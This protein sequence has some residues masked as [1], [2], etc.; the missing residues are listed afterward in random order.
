MRIVLFGPSGSGKGTL[1]GSLNKRYNLP[2]VSSGDI[3]RDNIEKRT[4][5]GIRVKDLVDNGEWVPDELVAD[6]ILDRLNQPDSRNG[7]IL[8]GVPRT[9]AQAKILQ[10]KS[11]I[12]CVIE[13]NVA[14][15]VVLKRLRNRRLCT[16]CKTDHNTIRGQF[17]KCRKCGSE[18]SQRADDMSDEKIMHRL[19]QYR[20]EQLPILSFYKDL[21]I[22][23]T[24]N[25]TED[26][27]PSHVLEETERCLRAFK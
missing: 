8:D 20:N 2:H 11:P 6:V 18:L 19:V 25:V 4:E 24:I 5:L 27:F 1:A 7:Y 23:C 26:M 21:G 3:F 10:K 17:D 22:L 13:I 15:D 14:D 12:N 9:L 16:N